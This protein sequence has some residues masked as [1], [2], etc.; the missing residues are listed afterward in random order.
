MLLLHL[1]SASL[2]PEGLYVY[3]SLTLSHIYV[4]LNNKV[5]YLLVFELYKN[6]L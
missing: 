2:N 1:S 6:A 5:L 4:S 3:N